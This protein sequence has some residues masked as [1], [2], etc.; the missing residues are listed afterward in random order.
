MTG[1]YASVN[2]LS[3]FQAELDRLLQE[4]MGLPDGEIAAG[5]WQPPLDIV[6]TGSSVLILVELPGFAASDLVVEVQGSRLVLSGIK[7][8]PAA[9]GANAH[10]HCMERS[11]GR[12]GREIQLFWPVNSH[13]G[14]AQL[15]D[16]LLKIEFP[17]IENKRQEA[18]RLPI[19]E[20]AA[21]GPQ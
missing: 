14:T 2:F 3:R 1:R 12:F 10:F 6:D 13:L 11:Q 15:A 8:A 16:G 9:A 19:T 5:E 18:R 21:G 17:K 4:V 20:P 7:Q